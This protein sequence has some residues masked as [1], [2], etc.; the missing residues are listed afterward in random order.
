MTA[1]PM[2]SSVGKTSRSEMFRSLVEV[3][4]AY[5]LSKRD[6]IARYVMS[7]YSPVHVAM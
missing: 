2:S 4:K 7:T 5:E 6:T 3:A 1:W